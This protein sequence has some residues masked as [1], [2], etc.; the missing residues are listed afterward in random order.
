MWIV[1]STLFSPIPWRIAATHLKFFPALIHGQS[2]ITAAVFL[3]RLWANAG[4]PGTPSA[5][6]LARFQN[7][8]TASLPL[9]TG[10]GYNVAGLNTAISEFVTNVNVNNNALFTAAKA[11]EI[12]L[13]NHCLPAEEL[14]AAVDAFCQKLLSGAMNAIRARMAATVGGGTCG[15][16]SAKC[17]SSGQRSRSA[18]PR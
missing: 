11:A 14:D 2:P 4:L 16:V 8:D 7:N 17:I 3:A 10:R 5:L 13:I 18:S 15:S 1:P 9:A 6:D 12:G